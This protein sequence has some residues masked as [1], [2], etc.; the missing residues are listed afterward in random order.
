MKIGK[1]IFK[2]KKNHNSPATATKFQK[3]HVKSSNFT[4]EKTFCGT[5]KQNNGWNRVINLSINQTI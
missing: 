1:K 4:I 3:L 2:M 5:K